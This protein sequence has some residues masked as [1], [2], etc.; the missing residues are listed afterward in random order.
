MNFI[1]AHGCMHVYTCTKTINIIEYIEK[2]QYKNYIHMS[3][4]N[5]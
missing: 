4:K 5:F 2:T 3:R 1:H